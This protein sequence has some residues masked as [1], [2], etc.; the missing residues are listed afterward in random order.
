VRQIAAEIRSR[1]DADL[2][3][4]PRLIADALEHAA[5]TAES[6]PV[7]DWDA[8]V[9]AGEHLELV[10]T[11]AKRCEQRSWLLEGLARELREFSDAS[12]PYVVHARR[13]LSGLADADLLVPGVDAALR[14]V[15]TGYAGL[16]A[17]GAYTNSCPSP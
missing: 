16:S 15:L 2:P 10:Q 6:M 17:D 14:R 4:R 12:D 13:I 9:P 8:I 7:D 11:W 1:S 3:D 5:N